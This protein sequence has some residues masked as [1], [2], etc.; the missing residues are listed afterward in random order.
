MVNY[1]RKMERAHRV[2]YMLVKG[3]IPPGK[4]IMHSCDNPPCCNP[5]HLSV[6]TIADNAHDM[7]SKGRAHNAPVRG[8][9]HYYSRLTEQQVIE[10]RDLAASGIKHTPIAAQFGISVSHV[11]HIVDGQIWRHVPRMDKAGSSYALQIKA[12]GK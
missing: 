1:R 6:G 12:V 2:A 7:K 9:S 11:G 3:P 4:L 5:D 10:I 8:E